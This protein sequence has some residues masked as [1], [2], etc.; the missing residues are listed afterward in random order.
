M[1]GI[2]E[3]HIGGYSGDQ[4]FFVAYAQVCNFKFV[5]VLLTVHQ[6]DL[7]IAIYVSL[8]CVYV[9]YKR[10]WVFLRKSAYDEYNGILG[11]AVIKCERVKLG[12]ILHAN[13]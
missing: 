8:F 12:Q 7:Y 13:S 6:S 1:N 10:L 2:A 9:C 3:Q 11:K 5:I 4:L